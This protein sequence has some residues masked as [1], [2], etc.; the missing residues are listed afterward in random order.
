MKKKNY[1][2]Q[3]N[4]IQFFYF[5]SRFF[6][7]KLILIFFSGTWNATCWTWP[8]KRTATSSCKSR[9]S[10]PTSQTHA[11]RGTSARSGA[12]RSARNSSGRA[13]TSGSS[14]CPSPLY[15][16]DTQTPSPRSRLASS[17]LWWRPWWTSGTR[18]SSRH[19]LATWWVISGGQ[20]FVAIY[21]AE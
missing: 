16:I 19:W 3:I 20:N 5:L 13:T 8:R 4:G 21:E 10:V 6:L 17:S 14:I 11:A 1:F 7:Q 9:S 15:V 18:F 2:W 12:R